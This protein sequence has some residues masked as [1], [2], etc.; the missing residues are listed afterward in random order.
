MCANFW[1]GS[2]ERGRKFHWKAWKHLQER[3]ANG[4]TSFRNLTRF[5]KA[6]LAKQVWR[7]IENP[8]SLVSRIFK[9]HYFKH[10]D[11]MDAPIGSNPSYICW[12]LSWSRDILTRGTYWKVSNGESIN[13]CRDAWIPGLSTGTSPPIVS[14]ESITSI[15]HLINPW[16]RLL[17]CQSWLLEFLHYYH[18]PQLDL[19]SGELLV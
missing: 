15:N 2:S 13:I 11:I 18:Y 3:K 10:V 5:N 1:W 14:Y 17:H 16:E 9:A 8:N 4:C 19:V 6:L 7:M 12:S